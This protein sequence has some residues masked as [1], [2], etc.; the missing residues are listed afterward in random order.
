MRGL[1]HWPSTTESSTGGGEQD[2]S[3]EGMKKENAR[4]ARKSMALSQK[5]WKISRRGTSIHSTSQHP[6][7]P[8]N[9][10]NWLVVKVPGLSK[11]WC[12]LPRVTLDVYEAVL[13]DWAGL[14]DLN[15]KGEIEDVSLEIAA[16]ERRTAELL[17]R[18]RDILSESCTVTLLCHLY[19]P[20][21]QSNRLRAVERR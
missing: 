4:T 21:C 16:S 6:Q 9:L 15:D 2:S 1:D 12:E 20:F 7:S 5:Q 13:D 19:V 11:S 17:T 8:Q 3:G 10:Q 18:F 14:P